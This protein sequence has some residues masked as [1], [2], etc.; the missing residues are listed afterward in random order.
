MR[1]AFTTACDTQA[2]P[3]DQ[4]L[5]EGKQ[6]LVESSHVNGQRVED[7]VLSNENLLGSVAV[8]FENRRDAIGEPNYRGLRI[9]AFLFDQMSRVAGGPS[10][11]VKI[12]QLNRH[13]AIAA[14]ALD[15]N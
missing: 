12:V 9:G 1:E 15:V 5:T 14:H 8:F 11:I 6:E 13:L 7:R 10:Q 2:G 4:R 3:S